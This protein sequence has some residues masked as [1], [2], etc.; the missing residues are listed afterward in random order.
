[1][2]KKEDY[3]IEELNHQQLKNING[4]GDKGIWYY[5]GYAGGWVHGKIEMGF[6]S[7]KEFVENTDWSESNYLNTGR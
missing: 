1:M 2:K 6:E 5:I 7:L 4:G 3:L